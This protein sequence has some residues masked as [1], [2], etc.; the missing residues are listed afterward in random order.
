MA[1]KPSVANPNQLNLVQIRLPGWLKNEVAKHCRKK[2]V[3]V[4]AWMTEVIRSALRADKGVP[5]PPPA[6][7]P[8]PTLADE[9]LAYTEGRTLISPC[10]K[11]A[12]CE[13]IEKG[14]FF[15]HGDMSFCRVCQIRVI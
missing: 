11:T 2:G 9:L 14:D 5:D 15:V 4:N 3:S 8:L 10:G 7:A 12:P 1:R 13:G 6:V